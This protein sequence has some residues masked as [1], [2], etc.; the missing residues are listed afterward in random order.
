MNPYSRSATHT[1]LHETPTLV[2]TADVG[3]ISR[4]DTFTMTHKAEMQRL[5]AAVRRNYREPFL[6]IAGRGAVDGDIVGYGGG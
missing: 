2:D 5:Q 6:T 1:T 4:R 3:R